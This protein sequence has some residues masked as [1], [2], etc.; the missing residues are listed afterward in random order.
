MVKICYKFVTINTTCFPT[1]MAKVIVGVIIKRRLNKT[2]K[3]VACLSHSNYKL[4]VKL[5]AGICGT[6][7]SV[8]SYVMW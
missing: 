7:H 8:H 1:N 2:N 3:N 6:L 4:L 5:K